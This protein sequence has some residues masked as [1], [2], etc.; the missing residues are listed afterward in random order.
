[1]S[2]DS[3]GGG[4]GGGAPNTIVTWIFIVIGVLVAVHLFEKWILGQNGPLISGFQQPQGNGRI[5][6]PTGNDCDLSNPK[7][8]QRNGKWYICR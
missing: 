5:G 4:H 8:Y 7:P 3:H 2:G 6:A 1:M